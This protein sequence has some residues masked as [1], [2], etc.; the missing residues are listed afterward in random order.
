MRLVL[1][2]ALV[3]GRVAAAD[4]AR[5]LAILKQRIDQDK[6]A[7]GIVVGLVDENGARVVAH[8]VPDGSALL[9]I[10]S[11][12]K[13]FTG[14]LLAEMI[15]RGEV[16]LDDP[17]RKYLPEGLVLPT[18]GGKEITLG[19]LTTQSSGLPRLPFN[20]QPS[21]PA[22]PYADYTAERL[23][24][25]LAKIQLTHD[26]YAHYEYSN[27]GVGLL[28]HVLSL[29]AGKPYGELLRERVLAPLGMNDTVIELD[30]AR[31]ARLAPGHL[32]TLEPAKNWDLGVL[33]GAGALRS[34]AG[35][36]LKLLKAQLGFLKID[37]P[38][39]KALARAPQ[40]LAPTG[41]DGLEVGMGWHILKRRGP[42]IVWHNGGTGGYRSWMGFSVERKLGVVVLSDTAVSVDDIGL[43]LMDS[44]Y[45]LTSYTRNLL[46]R[47]MM[48][49][50]SVLRQ[51]VGVYRVNPVMNMVITLEDGRL[52]V[53]ATGQPK[54]RMFAESPGRFFMRDVEAQVEFGSNGLIF[55]RG[56]ESFAA[57][58]IQ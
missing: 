57:E 27:L 29:R 52:H 42:P 49:E 19:S 1:L 45:R 43:H 23:Y 41:S 22:N 9:E 2:V 25:A 16:A 55:R 58:K 20:L 5:V 24:A 36:L 6:K 38:L 26:P 13:V 47:E 4:D 12:T 39:G 34:T 31:R 56:G 53:Q 10:G 28:G 32:P 15:E 18:R 8:G 40:T 33:A 51:H 17:I 37:G 3:L 11:V 54:V 30:E 14:I 46:R 44:G 48:L 35:D 50:E 21:D 7:R